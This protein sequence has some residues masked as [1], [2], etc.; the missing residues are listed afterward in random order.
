MN[1]LS[2]E[3]K[4]LNHSSFFF[5]YKYLNHSS[6]LVICL[7]LSIGVWYLLYNAT[8][9][10]NYNL[11][12]SLLVQSLSEVTVSENIIEINEHRLSHDVRLSISPV[13]NSEPL[14][15]EKPHELQNNIKETSYR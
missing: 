11:S 10:D 12:C 6:Y 4:H 2:Y 14:L 13:R 7:S 1:I 5:C 8:I 15:L 9:W 3:L